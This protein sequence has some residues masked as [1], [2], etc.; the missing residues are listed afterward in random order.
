M[1]GCQVI[2]TSPLNKIE[3][4]TQKELIKILF[5]LLFKLVG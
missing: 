3:I 5:L 4:H 2:Q 1:S